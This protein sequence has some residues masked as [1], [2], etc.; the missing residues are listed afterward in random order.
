[1]DKYSENEK[2]RLIRMNTAYQNEP[3]WSRP[4]TGHQITFADAT[5]DP[6]YQVTYLD[7]TFYNRLPENDDTPLGEC[8]TPTG[9]CV[10][11]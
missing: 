5:G 4:R 2:P 9:C 11:S 10:I 7:N 1:M 8:V 6:L 3:P